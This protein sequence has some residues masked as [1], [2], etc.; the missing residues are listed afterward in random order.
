MT[1]KL[2]G[3]ALALRNIVSLAAPIYFFLVIGR[4]FAPCEESTLK[5]EVGNACIGYMRKVRRWLKPVI[6]P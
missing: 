2:V 5:K 4:I 3:L 6:G 1:L